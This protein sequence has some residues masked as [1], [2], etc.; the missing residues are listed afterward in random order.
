MITVIQSQE[1]EKTAKDLKNVLELLESEKI[2]FFFC[3]SDDVKNDIKELRY[4]LSRKNYILGEL[5]LVDWT[6][7]GLINT[8]DIQQNIQSV[9]DEIILKSDYV[10]FIFGDKFG[11]NTMHEWENCIH[12][13]KR[14]PRILLGLKQTSINTEEKRSKL[15]SR[16]VVVDCAY[17]NIIEFEQKIVDVLIAR[18]KKRKDKALKIIEKHMENFSSSDWQKIESKCTEIEKHAKEYNV[19]ISE[20][21]IEIKQM[22]PKLSIAKVMPTTIKTRMQINPCSNKV[23]NCSKEKKL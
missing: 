20:S 11:A 18:Q 4:S 22:A 8:H 9:F 13:T 15:G 19:P 10:V 2:H 17:S 21:I 16:N 1:A 3:S 23:V 7:L 14:K 5:H 6:D 12:N